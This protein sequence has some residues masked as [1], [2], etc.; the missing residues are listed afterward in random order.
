MRVN[1]T[2][3]RAALFAGSLTGALGAAALHE[4][5]AESWRQAGWEG[6]DQLAEPY[7]ASL[8]AD[9]PATTSPTG[10]AG[11]LQRDWEVWRDPSKVATRTGRNYVRIYPPVEAPVS[12]KR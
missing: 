9:R 10:G 7:A 5:R 4:E 8:S 6:F 2:F 3:Q 1:E 12:D 11:E